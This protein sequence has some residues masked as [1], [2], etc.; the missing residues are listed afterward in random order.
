[1]AEMEYSVA[2]MR[3]AVLAQSMLRM[4]FVIAFLLIAALGH[5]L[6]AGRVDSQA[7]VATIPQANYH[8]VLV[9][10]WGT[11]GTAAGQFDLPHGIAREC[12]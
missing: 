1:M 7:G 10:L 6:T 11:K 3:P 4:A 8:V 2:M 12:L 5:D 9:S